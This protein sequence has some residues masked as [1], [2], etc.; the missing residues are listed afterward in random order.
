MNSPAGALL[1]TVIVLLPAYAA[2]RGQRIRIAAS[3][4]W[5]CWKIMR[6]TRKTIQAMEEL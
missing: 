1:A 3:Y 6:L 5:A 2:Y 4:Y